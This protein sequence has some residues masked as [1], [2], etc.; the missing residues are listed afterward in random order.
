MSILSYFVWLIFFASGVAGAYF[1]PEATIPLDGKFVFVGAWGAVV[2]FIYY[3]VCKRKAQEA[4]ENYVESLNASR[5]ASPKTEYIPV[6]PMVG[7]EVAKSPVSVRNPFESIL[8]PGAIPAK[9]ALQKMDTLARPVFPLESWNVFCKDIFKNRPFPEVVESLEKVLPLLFP[10]AAGILYMYGDSQ[11]ELCKIFSFGDYT[12]SDDVIMPA[13]CASFNKGDI[14]ITDFS[15]GKF[16]GGCTHLHHHPQGISFCVPIEGL[17]E[18]FGILT[19]QVDKLPDGE[20]LEFWKAK[21][22]IVA[23]TFGLYVA[24]Q[25]LNIRFQQ[26]CIRDNL[27]GLFNKRYM[28]ESLRRE[29][30]SA[31]RHGTPIGIIMLHPDAVESIQK[32]RGRHAVEQML[33]ELGQRLP[34]YI[35]TE[36]IPCLYEGESFCIILPG[37]DFKI[38]SDRAEKIR[39][40]ISQL[41]VS[42]G[43]IVLSTTLSMGVSVLPIHAVDVETL[44]YAAQASMQLAIENG[45]NR[46]VKA[47]ELQDQ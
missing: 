20:D 12:I 19:I 34:N 18:H 4:E 21:V 24:N 44:I 32:T 22:S 31:N 33:W 15:S 45:G 26:H 3:I 14:V 35:R 11:A 30:A 29:I 25:N 2:G 28:E 27:T 16:S 7:D 40:E 37:A 5:Q 43:D 42:Y 13:E 8:P 6:V 10:K 17:E 38:T 39:Y 1:I 36:D 46:V 9:E 23:A 41:Q 47:D